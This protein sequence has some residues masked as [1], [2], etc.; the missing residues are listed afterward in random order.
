MDAAQNETENF[1]V[2]Y[3]WWCYRTQSSCSPSR[4]QRARSTLTSSAAVSRRVITKQSIVGN[5]MNIRYN[6]C[7]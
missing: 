2:S 6:Y 4:R 7:G 3:I 1:A 5:K